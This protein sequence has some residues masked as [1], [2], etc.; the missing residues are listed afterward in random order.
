M[1]AGAN[2]A[3][4]G[5]FVA[6][7]DSKGFCP[8][9]AWGQVR[10]SLLLPSSFTQ[11]ASDPRVRT[12]KVGQIGRAASIFGVREIVIFQDPAFNDTRFVEKLLSYQECPPYL[13]KRLFGLAPELEFA[14]LLPP[15]NTPAHVVGREPR[16]GELREGVALPGGVEIGA[17]RLAE[18]APPPVGGQRLTVRVSAVGRRLSAE[19]VLEPP[20]DY[21]AGY[22][23]RRAASLGEALQGFDLR[24]ATSRTGTPA[25][26]LP[27]TAGSAR[28][29]IAFGSP[30]KG[31]RRFVEEERLGEAFDSWINTLPGQATR[32][33][34]TEEAVLATL[35]VLRALEQKG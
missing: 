31:L 27:K 26:G 1:G 10:L 3:V 8:R 23:V 22:V 19:P 9:R 5:R 2:E 15:L 28:V 13:R 34:R 32:T 21:Y 11:D 7:R 16:E 12:I 6:A 14:G 18:C 35:A 25:A 33:V 20:S 29:A 17:D 24:I 4:P 30:E